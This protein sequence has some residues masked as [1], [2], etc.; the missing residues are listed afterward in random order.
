[1][2][3]PYNSRFKH[4]ADFRV[5]YRFFSPQEGG[6]QTLPYQGYRSDFWYEQPANA[7]TNKLFMIYPEFEDEKGG[8][9]MDADVAV[10]QNGYARMWILNPPMRSYHLDKIKVGVKG[11]FMEGSRRVAECEVIEIL[12]LMVNPI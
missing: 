3:L 7:D 10:L 11:Y 9:I 4:E 8:I 5:A 12:D 6:R 2:F 1:M